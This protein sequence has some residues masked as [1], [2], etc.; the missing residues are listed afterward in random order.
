M[1]HIVCNVF[2]QQIL[3]KQNTICLLGLWHTMQQLRGSSKVLVKLNISFDL[4][5]SFSST[6]KSLHTQKYYIILTIDLKATSVVT[7]SVTIDGV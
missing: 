4:N 3:I 6:L 1:H 5:P 2:T 7:Q